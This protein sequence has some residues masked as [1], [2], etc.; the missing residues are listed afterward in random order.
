[1]PRRITGGL[2][3]I[4][5]IG[6]L[7]ADVLQLQDRM[8]SLGAL[9]YLTLWGYLFF[10]IVAGAMLFAPVP[11]GRWLVTALASLLALYAV[12]IWV[13]A[14]GAPLWGQLWCS[15]MLFFAVWSIYVVHKRNA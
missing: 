7:L 11:L 1:M 4:F 10:C 13:K 9:Y 3:V 6:F 15:V 8:F 14:E 5:G 12:L 2:W